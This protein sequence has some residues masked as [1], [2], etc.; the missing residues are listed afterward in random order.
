MEEGY[1]SYISFLWQATK[2]T[3]EDRF[4]LVSLINILGEVFKVKFF[5]SDLGVE[6]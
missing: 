3:I 1:W 5:A 6:S 2:N 4:G